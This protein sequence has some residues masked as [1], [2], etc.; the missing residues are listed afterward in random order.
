MNNPAMDET[1]V[2]PVEKRKFPFAFQGSGGTLFGIQ[3]V[4]LLLIIVTLGIYY[5]WAK[6]RVRTYVWRQV[7]FDGDRFAYHGTG[8]EVLIGW[9]KAALIF[10]IPFFAF[11]NAPALLGAP[12]AVILIGAIASLLLIALFI[13]IATVGT[14][15]YRMSRS[16]FRGIRFS[17]RGRWQDYAKLFFICMALTTITL[18]LYM[19]YFE[20]RSQT[21]LMGKSH[22]GNEKFG[23][24][25]KG[26]DLILSYV[27]C[28]I[29]A[30][31][32]L[33]LSM[34]WYR[35]KKTKYRWDRTT[36]GAARFTSTITFGG[37]LGLYLVNAL[38]LIFTLGFGAPWVQVRTLRYYLSNLTLEG[39]L[40]PASII[41]DAA[42]ASAFGEGVG[43]F[44]DMDFDLG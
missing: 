39:R 12:I 32:T 40:D 38:I 10:G 41:Q 3:I 20:M 8:T 36:F 43:D 27:L 2:A 22:F 4:N 23:F 18:G 42:Q 1:T 11:Q 24:D 30:F 13:P 16:S 29:L 14:R 34:L 31:P 26:G 9:L 6:A 21:F 28:L 25:G 17:F 44:L 33:M 15:R 35:Y 7:E 5:F 19:P 37:L